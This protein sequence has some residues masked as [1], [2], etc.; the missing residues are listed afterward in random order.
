MGFW[1]S[2]D[3]ED[4]ILLCHDK[5][6]Y[7]LFGLRTTPT[8][9]YQLVYLCRHGR[10]FHHGTG[11]R[12]DFVRLLHVNNSRI[13]SNCSLVRLHRWRNMKPSH[14]SRS[15]KI[16]IRIRSNIERLRTDWD[17]PII[18]QTEIPRY[19]IHHNKYSRR[20]WDKT[21]HFQELSWTREKWKPRWPFDRP[22]P[23]FPY[24]GKNTHFGQNINPCSTKIDRDL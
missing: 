21:T 24:C 15:E 20:L 9:H 12:P 8:V 17:G 19:I 7:K 16:C 6:D 1:L 5:T 11:R 18:D 2:L 23:R 22:P 14:P 10:R 13:S 3:I 4:L